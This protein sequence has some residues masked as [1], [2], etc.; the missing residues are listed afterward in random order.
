MVAKRDL[1]ALRDPSEHGIRRTRLNAGMLPPPITVPDHVRELPVDEIDARNKGRHVRQNGDKAS[2]Q[3][4]WIHERSLE[5]DAVELR[6]VEFANHARSRLGYTSCLTAKDVSTVR[7]QRDAEAAQLRRKIRVLDNTRTA[8][9]TNKKHDVRQWNVLTRKITT[10]RRRLRLVSSD[11]QISR[12]AGDGG[13][14]PSAADEA[15]QLVVQIAEL[16]GVTTARVVRAVFG[17]LEG[18]DVGRFIAAEM[19]RVRVWKHRHS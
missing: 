14:P 10:L 13:R 8:Y 7:A 15:H 3:R 16:L 4:S 6:L 17:H 19:G 9:D 2:T 5:P 18:R 1:V 11:S 12:N